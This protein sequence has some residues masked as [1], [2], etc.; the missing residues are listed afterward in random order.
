MSEAPGP[1]QALVVR[2]GWEGHRPV[3]ATERFLPF[4]KANGFA[5]GVHEGPE[6]YADSERLAAPT[7]SSSATRWVWPPTSR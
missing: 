6:E 3:E 5:V 4:L 2:G 1:R 7:W